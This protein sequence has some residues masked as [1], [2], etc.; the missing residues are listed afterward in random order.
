MAMVEIA[1]SRDNFSSICIIALPRIRLDSSY[2]Y[3]K[4][5]LKILLQGNVR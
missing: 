3:D 1:S 4:I 5:N 2:K